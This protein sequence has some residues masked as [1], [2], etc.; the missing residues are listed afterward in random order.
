VYMLPVI[1]GAA[2]A[3]AVTT[4]LTID[5]E[6]RERA[7]AERD[8]SITIRGTATCS[9]GSPIMI[10]I[11][12]DVTQ[13]YSKSSVAIG[14]FADEVPC[15]NTASTWVVT[16]YPGGDLPFRPGSAS[17]GVN[18]SGVGPD[19]SGAAVSSVGVLQLTRSA[20]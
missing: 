16:V 17:I 9:T 1:L 4:S 5:F 10:S 11:R 3:A 6:F 18:A 19:G 7:T 20:R 2:L 13:E 15:G 8:G 12:G 14:T